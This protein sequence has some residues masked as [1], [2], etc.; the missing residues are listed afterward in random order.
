[1]LDIL[2]AIKLEVKSN[3]FR[4]QTKAKF[5]ESISSVKINSLRLKNVR[6][7]VFAYIADECVGIGGV[8][9]GCSDII[10][11]VFGKYKNFSGKSPMK[12]IGRAV[13]TI[14]V[15]TSNIDY[16]EV[17]NAME[18]ISAKDVS[19]WL[20]ENIGTSLFAKRRQAF[21]FKNPKVR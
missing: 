8:Y 5:K 3:G 21:K 4:K 16:K 17:K 18:S 14:P 6:D 2:H 10:E 13:L 7:E 1:M 15:F 11:S 19:V 20:R 9:P 12:E